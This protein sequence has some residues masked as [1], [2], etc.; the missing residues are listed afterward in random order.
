[1]SVMLASFQ[2]WCQ[3][4]LAYSPKLADRN[5]RS[6]TESDGFGDRHVASYTMLLNL[7]PECVR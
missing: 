2:D 1:M 5:I 7:N 4:V 3:T 6:R